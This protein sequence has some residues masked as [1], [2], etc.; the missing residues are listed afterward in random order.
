MT[1]TVGM[2]D[3]DSQ[4]EAF[5]DMLERQAERL[6]EREQAKQRSAAAPSEGD[7]A[8]AA[9]RRTL[10]LAL[11]DLVA[12]RDQARDERFRAHAERS[13]AAVEAQL[14][15]LDGPAPDEEQT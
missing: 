11:R 14:R 2:G 7:A 10:E 4:V 9:R 12:R 5:A 6:D 13:I 3:F 8:V 1:Y 15:G